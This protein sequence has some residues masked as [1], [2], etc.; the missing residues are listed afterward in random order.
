MHRLR[1]LLPDRHRSGSIY[2]NGLKL[3]VGK[4]LFQ[5]TI[6]LNHKIIFF[7]TRNVYPLEEKENFPDSITSR[8]SERPIG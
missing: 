3:P 2:A 8:M 4:I 1:I 6:S 5:E 7:L